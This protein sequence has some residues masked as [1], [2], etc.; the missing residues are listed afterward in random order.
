VALLVKPRRKPNWSQVTERLRAIGPADL[1]CS[2][3]LDP[4][5]V[6]WHEGPS[7]ATVQ[8]A[9]GELLGWEWRAVAPAVTP[10]QPPETGASTL[11]VR[12]SLSIPALAVAVVRFYGARGRYFTVADER[13]HQGFAEICDT[14]DPARSGYPIVDAIAAMLV[15]A[16]DPARLPVGGEIDALSARLRELG[17]ER[18]W[19]AAYRAVS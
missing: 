19:A 6:H 15:E 12:R 7:I 14:D 10:S 5:W 4:R 18:L 9:A 3:D 13:G 11:W 2:D 8:A 17:Y 16:V 1:T